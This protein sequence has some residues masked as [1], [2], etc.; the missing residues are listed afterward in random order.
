MQA[1][2]A[3]LLP[4]KPK[5]VAIRI[6]EA[7]LDDSAHR[8]GLLHVIDGYARGPSGQSAALSAMARQRLIQGLRAHPAALVLLAMDKEQTLGAA[9]CFWGFSTV[10]GEPLLN[11]HDLAVLPDHQGQGIGSRLIAAAEQ[12]ARRRCCCR[13][14]LE[15]LDS[16]EGAKRLYH[17]AGFGPWDQVTLFVSKDLTPP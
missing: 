5:S 3:R 12:R 16:N 7:D 8:R 2:V 4:G 11:I 1:Y 10:A 14:T 15:V 6:Q 9:V 17:R 13:M